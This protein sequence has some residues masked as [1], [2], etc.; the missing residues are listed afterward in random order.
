MARFHLMHC[1]PHP[2]MHGLHGYKDA[3]DAVGWGLAQLGHKV[4]Y[5]LNGYAPSA[6][7]IVFGAQVLPLHDLARMS[8]E[9]IV[10]N[11][12]QLRGLTRETI[13]PELHYC[14]EHLRLWDYSASNLESWSRLG[15]SARHVPVGYAPVLTRI[16]KPPTQDIDVLIYGLSGDKRLDALHRLSH[17]GLVVVFA[18]GLYGR[19]RDELIARAKF[20]LN[21]NLYDH[22]RVF[23]IVRVSYLLANRKAVLASLDENTAI[24][25]D[26]DGAIRITTLDRLVEDA[27]RLVDDADARAQLEAAGFD[28]FSRRD[29][30]PILRAALR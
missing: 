7:N 23:E 11:F 13:R 30:R 3:I 1:V 9:T 16:A 14:A 6:T 2:R 22:T 28:A 19:A 21:V 25:E 18:S 10:Y 4:S 12:E 5:G 8:P 27:L 24:E 29:I 26:L 15:A 20:V 17:A